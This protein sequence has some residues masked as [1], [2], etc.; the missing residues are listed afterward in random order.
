MKKI[1]VTVTDKGGKTKNKWK[2]GETISL[3]PKVAKVMEEKGFVSIGE[4]EIKKEKKQEQETEILDSDVVV[5]EFKKDHEENKKGDQ[6]EVLGQDAKELIKNK[7][8]KLV[9]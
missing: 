8:A 4:V 1:K 7:I 3:N 2:S 5:I 9:K 6:A